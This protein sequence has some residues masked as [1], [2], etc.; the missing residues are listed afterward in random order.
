MP[1]LA[2]ENAPLLLHIFGGSIAFFQD[3]ARKIYVLKDSL[4][5]GDMTKL[6]AIQEAVLQMTAPTALV[7]TVSTFSL[8]VF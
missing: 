1:W 5:R 8:F 3:V 2:F 4:N 6:K 7:I